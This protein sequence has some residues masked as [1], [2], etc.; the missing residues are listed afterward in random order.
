MWITTYRNA[1][2]LGLIDESE[3]QSDTLKFLTNLGLYD[4]EKDSV[5]IE[6]S[7]CTAGLSKLNYFLDTCL[8]GVVGLNFCKGD[9]SY[10]GK[11]FSYFEEFQSYFPKIRKN[12]KQGPSLYGF[13]STFGIAFK[14]IEGNGFSLSFYVEKRDDQELEWTCWTYTSDSGDITP[15]ITEIL[16]ILKSAGPPHQ[17]LNKIHSEETG[18]LMNIE[19]Q[20]ESVAAALSKIEELFPKAGGTRSY[21]FSCALPSWHQSK[22]ILD[23]NRIRG[24]FEGFRHIVM[25]HSASSISLEYNYAVLPAERDGCRTQRGIGTTRYSG[26]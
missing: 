3:E 5:E 1:S 13:S 20:E 8:K 26:W 15:Q 23:F 11:N 14:L 18:N 24:D 2:R 17:D 9:C 25:Q 7:D 16:Q 21:S 4:W 22:N 10:D 12:S 6:E 19:V